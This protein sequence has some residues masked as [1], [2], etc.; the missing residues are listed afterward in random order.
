MHKY[1]IVM[2]D[3]WIFFKVGLNHVLDIHGYD[4]LLFLIA[5]SVPYVLKDWKR[6]LILVSFFTLGHSI[7]LLLSVF[8][9]VSVKTFLVELLIPITILIAALFNIIMV[10][11]SPKNSNI[12]FVA[13]VTVFF[14]IIHGLGFSNYFNSILS[15]KPID[16]LAPLFEFAIGIE[17]AQIVVVLAVL[18]LAFISQT[19]FRFNK[20]DFTLIMSSFVIGVIVPILIENPIWKK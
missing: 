3:F 8:N 6:I 2:S 19:L 5:L 17:S 14:G 12:T 15:G 11:K 18:I 4:H 13:S 1:E 10:G 7:S 20:R 16:K 9:V